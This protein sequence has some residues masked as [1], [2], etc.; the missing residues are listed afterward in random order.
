[1]K[2]KDLKEI[3]FTFVE[4][5]ALVVSHAKGYGVILPDDYTFVV[6]KEGNKI[7][8]TWEEETDHG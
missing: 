7:S 6:D 1:M 4:L 2:S 8:F 3:T 5:A